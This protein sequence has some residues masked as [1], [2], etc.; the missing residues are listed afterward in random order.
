MAGA[1]FQNIGFQKISPL[2]PN[3]SAQ[4]IHLLTAGTS[5]PLFQSLTSDVRQAVVEQIT[6]SIRNG[7]IVLIAGSAL[8]FIGSLFLGVSVFLGFFVHSLILV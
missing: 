3:A 5:S 1:L 6:L 7:F 4:D 8:G 2:L